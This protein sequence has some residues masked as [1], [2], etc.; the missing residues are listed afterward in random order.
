MYDG[1][2]APQVDF[3][4]LRC[5]THS[6]NRPCVNDVESIPEWTVWEAVPA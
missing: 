1:G 5:G 6:L 3:S 2:A 4:Q